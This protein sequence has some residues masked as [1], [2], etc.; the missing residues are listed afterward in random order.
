MP[1]TPKGVLTGK[2]TGE[3]GEPLQGFSV[4]AIR[5]Q[6]LGGL[7]QLVREGA[8]SATNDLGEYRVADLSPAKYFVVVTPPRSVALTAAGS[9]AP[10]APVTVGP[11]SEAGGINFVLR[12]TPV[13]HIRGVVASAATGK[14]VSYCNVIAYPKVP[15]ILFPVQAGS[16]AVNDANGLFDIAG[17]PP[18]SYILMARQADPS[19][20]LS[21]AGTVDLVREDLENLRIQFG[22][23]GLAVAVR[24]QT[25]GDRDRTK[26]SPPDLSKV[27]VAL[28]FDDLP[29]VPMASAKLSGEGTAFFSN[30][31]AQKYRLRIAGL[32]PGW[33][34]KSARL[35]S[36]DVLAAGFSFLGSTSPLEVILDSSA[37]QVNGVVLGPDGK[38]MSRVR[39]TLIPSGVP[40][41]FDLIRRVLTEENG[42]FIVESVAHGDYDAYA[43]ADLDYPIPFD[44]SFLAAFK[45]KAARVSFDGTSFRSVELKAITPEEIEDADRRV[46]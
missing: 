39:V 12:K 43:W 21:V 2:V 37:S 33:Y 41:R 30:L 5:Y 18:G 11:V 28:A 3:D 6:F 19:G 32:P 34:L 13:L 8:T 4:L 16:F 7:R 40:M 1:L 29:A 38:G 26:G 44:P 25:G 31:S 22:G 14:P 46:Q 45:R 42:A 36:T 9:H 23:E 15:G 27:T 17:L 24:L 20:L 35:G 10:S